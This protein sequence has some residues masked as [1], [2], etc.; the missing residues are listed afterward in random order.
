MPKIKTKNIKS[1][2]KR[3]ILFFFFALTAMA[4]KAQDS[5]T[6]CFQ[7][8]SKAQGEMATLVYPDF[9]TCKT[10]VLHPATDNEG[11][12]V[13]NIPALR[14]LHIQIWDDNKIRGVVENGLSLICRPGTKAE[15]LLDDINDRCIFTGE[16]AEAHHAQIAHPLKIENFHGRMFDM[17]MQE[18]AG[19]IRSI[20]KD[21][22]HRIDTLSKAHP[23]LPKAYVE[24]LRQMVRYS[25]AMDM[26]QNIFG[27]VTQSMGVMM[28]NNSLPKEYIDLLREVETKELLF[29]QSPLPCDATTYFRDIVSLEGFVQNGFFKEIPEGVE[30]FDFY[31]F[32]SQIYACP[33]PNKEPL[34]NISALV[35]TPPMCSLLQTAPLSPLRH[36][37]PAPPTTSERPF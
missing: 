3:I 24:S 17:D 21:N 14:T 7:L 1:M 33:M 15:I 29:P 12:W 16:N 10:I 2:N 6:V 23:E 13:V 28:Q 19:Y 18:A 20:Y 27:H 35:D 9:I 5:V 25:Y 37:A 30:D 26:T 4:A 34:R 8:A 31:S 32:T 11:R 22:C 36:H